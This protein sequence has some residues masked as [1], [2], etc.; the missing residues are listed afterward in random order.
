MHVWDELNVYCTTYDTVV[1]LKRNFFKK[2]I[3]FIKATFPKFY[4]YGLF[5][6]IALNV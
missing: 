5:L 6:D 1:Y 2:K 3:W 4:L